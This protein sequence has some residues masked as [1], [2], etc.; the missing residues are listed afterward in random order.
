MMLLPPQTQTPDEEDH[1]PAARRQM[2]LERT[3]YLMRSGIDGDK[4]EFLKKSRGSLAFTQPCPC[5]SSRPYLGEL[6][7]KLAK[8]RPTP[9]LR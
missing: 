5:L 7:P 3:E 8:R 6:L 2:L 9:S 1:H 4:C